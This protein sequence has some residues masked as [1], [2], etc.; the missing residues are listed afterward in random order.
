MSQQYEYFDY[1]A[2]LTGG[3]AYLSDYTELGARVKFW[4]ES[5]NWITVEIRKLIG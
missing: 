2:P 3:I 5:Q 4:Q 1:V